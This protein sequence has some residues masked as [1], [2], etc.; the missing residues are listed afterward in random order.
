MR[1]TL[2]DT[3]TIFA[4]NGDTLSGNVI[5]TVNSIMSFRTNSGDHLVSNLMYTS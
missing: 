2:E 5:S 4:D 3:G 1:S